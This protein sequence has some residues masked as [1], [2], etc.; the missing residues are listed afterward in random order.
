LLPT[1]KG[2]GHASRERVWDRAGGRLM[3]VLA[4]GELRFDRFEV[5]WS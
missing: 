2:D 5:D 3:F 4:A 1:T